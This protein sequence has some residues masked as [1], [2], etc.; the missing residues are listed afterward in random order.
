MKKINFKTGALTA[1]I[2]LS[3]LA[4]GGTARSEA[5]DPHNSYLG[6]NFTSTAPEPPAAT[7]IWSSEMDVQADQSA[8]GRGSAVAGEGRIYLIQQGQL[9]ALNAQTGKR[10]WKYG[11]KLIAPL[12]YKDGVIYASSQAGTLYAVNAAT[13]KNKW[14]SS[15]PSKTPYQLLIDQDQLF[16]V[17]GDI[18]AYNL[19][20][21]KLRWKEDYTE[22]LYL[23]VQVQGDLVLAED[24][25]SG[26]Y[27][28]DVLHAFDRKTGKQLWDASNHALPIAA[29]S[30][31]LLSQ[32]TSS[33]VNMLPLTTLDTLDA[34]TGKVLKSVEYNPGNVNPDEVLN[35]GGKAWVSGK[36]LYINDGN[37]VYCYPADADPA[38]TT[39]I[40]YSAAG[41]GKSLMYAAGPY[42]GRVL[43]S[44]GETVYGVKTTNRYGVSYYGGIAIARFD[45]LG[46]GMYIA[47]TDGQLVAVNLLTGALVLQLK[48]S[49]RVFGPTLLENGMI[50]VQSKGKVTA[51][52]EPAVLKMG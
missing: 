23:P 4:A 45:L 26:A 27:M 28:Y 50:I 47:R 49:G 17:N 3:L 52:K 7:T 2:G 16:A 43:F 8:A 48:T 5:S 20:D 22:T 39:K 32:Q 33:L 37:T 18:Q 36:Q 12:L 34:K 29:G 9:L 10:V 46:H 40:T 14:S 6:D 15:G 30:G 38:K 41:G 35:S 13:G 1:L 25:I 31:T 24:T 51:F 21:G 11:A 42:D 19:K 44:D